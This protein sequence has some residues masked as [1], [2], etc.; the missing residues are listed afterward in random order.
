MFV[1][2][3][4]VLVIGIVLLLLVL[5]VLGFAGYYA[6]RVRQI[7]Y[8][9]GSFECAWRRA[10][11]TGWMSGGGMY[12]DGILEWHRLMSLSRKP[13]RSWQR[14][15]LEITSCTHSGDV[16]ELRMKA[17]ESLFELRMR[18]KDYTG[19]VAWLDAAP[20]TPQSLY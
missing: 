4:F 6:W 15:E 12:G 18:Q 10:Y 9:I 20:P 1:G 7:A 8:Q 14:D 16:V 5:A 13:Y 2:T 3:I 11:G 19:L 17:G